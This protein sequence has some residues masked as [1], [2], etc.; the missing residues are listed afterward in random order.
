LQAGL[1]PVVVDPATHGKLAAAP[2]SEVAIDLRDQTLTLPDGSAAVFPMEPFARH[3][4]LEG[5]DALSFLLSQ[6]AAI[7]AYEKSR[8]SPLGGPAS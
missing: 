7:A 5:L 4:L 6:E 3:C 8:S 1:L 2:G